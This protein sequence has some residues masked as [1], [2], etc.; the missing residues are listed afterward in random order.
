MREHVQIAVG[1]VAGFL[2][3]WM[4]VRGLPGEWVL[5]AVYLALVLVRDGRRRRLTGRRLALYLLVAAALG[6]AFAFVPAP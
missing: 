6:A 3:L 5:P 1:V 4:K 2:V